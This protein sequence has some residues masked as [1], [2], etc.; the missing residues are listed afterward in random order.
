MCIF[1]KKEIKLIQ[2]LL[3]LHRVF[4]KEMEI[5]LFMKMIVEISNEYRKLLVGCVLSGKIMDKIK[6]K[7]NK[8][9]K[10]FVVI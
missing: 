7:I 5:A 9:K 6:S 3:C 10:R 4:Q 2:K 1:L 8:N